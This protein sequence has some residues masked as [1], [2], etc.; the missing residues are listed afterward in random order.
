MLHQSA[1]AQKLSA[2]PLLSRAGQCLWQL[3][4]ARLT[5]VTPVLLFRARGGFVAEL[6]T[7]HSLCKEFER[8]S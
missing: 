7:S 8:I 4:K 5:M 2:S 6:L 1:S 3:R